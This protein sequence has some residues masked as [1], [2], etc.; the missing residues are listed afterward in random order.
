MVFAL[1][2]TLFTAAVIQSM[3]LTPETRAK[4]KLYSSVFSSI[5]APCAS[6]LFVSPLCYKVAPDCL[7]IFPN[8]LI[9]YCK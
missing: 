5:V 6:A 9:N 1:C 8:A 3:S 7:S 2:L 4:L